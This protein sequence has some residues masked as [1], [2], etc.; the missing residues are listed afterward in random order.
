MQKIWKIGS[1]MVCV[2]EFAASLTITLVV[3]LGQ[4]GIHDVSREDEDLLRE[5]WDGKPLVY[6]RNAL[7]WVMVGF[8]WV[9]V[10]LGV[11]R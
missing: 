9:Q 2:F 5:S 7:L 8:C 6:T 3:A 10:V 4:V 11:W 1:A